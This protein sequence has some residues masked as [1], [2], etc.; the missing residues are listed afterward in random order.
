MT[1]ASEARYLTQLPPSNV[2]GRNA[3]IFTFLRDM[4]DETELGG[5]HSADIQR[6]A[7]RQFGFVVS[8]LLVLVSFMVMPGTVRYLGPNHAP[9]HLQAPAAAV[10]VRA[11]R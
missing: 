11:T 2:A 8:A 6:S 10:L 1:N 5:R 9:G 4:P 3:R 7:R